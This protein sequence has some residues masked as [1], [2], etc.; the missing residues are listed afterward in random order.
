M[1][2]E[3]PMYTVYMHRLFDGRTYIGITSQ[4]LNRRWQNGYGYRGSQKF[5]HA[6]E[7]YGWDSFEHIVL[8]ENI[9]KEDAEQE[10][11][12]LIKEFKSNTREFGFN[13]DL[14]GSLAGKMSDETKEKIRQKKIGLRAS[15]E[16]KRKMSEARKGKKQTEEHIKNRAATR[17]GK[18]LSEETKR[19]ISVAVSEK[20]K[21]RKHTEETKK[22]IRESSPKK[23]KVLQFE[24]NGVFVAEHQSLSE[25]AKSVG[26]TVSNICNCASGLR[27]T[28]RGYIWKYEEG[29]GID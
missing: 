20:Q 1:I 25:A 6:I 18:H 2:G 17:V 10:E 19:K 16:T 11:I 8:I 12:R 9:S 5:F 4:K 23:R 24:K 13:T 29:C 14:G 27:K 26:T 28:A 3:N 15:D 22:K 21:G 7:K